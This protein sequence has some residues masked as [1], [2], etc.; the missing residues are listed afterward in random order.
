[1]GR[2]GRKHNPGILPIPARQHKPGKTKP[3]P[4]SR[5][6]NKLPVRE[7]IISRA[8]KHKPGEKATGEARLFLESSF[9]CFYVPPA[10]FRCFWNVPSCVATLSATCCR[11]EKHRPPANQ[12]ALRD[13]VQGIPGHTG[14]GNQA[15]NPLIVVVLN[16]GVLMIRIGFWAGVPYCSYSRFCLQTLF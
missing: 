15:G 13:E 3:R 14:L 5:L 10:V 7:Y 4:H 1:M 2:S 16:I 11:K 12:G 9:L 6:G 8:G